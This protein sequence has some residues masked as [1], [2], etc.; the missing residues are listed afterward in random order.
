MGLWAIVASP[1]RWELPSLTEK[2][3]GAPF[4]SLCA[5]GFPLW[6]RLI[7]PPGRGGRPSGRAQAPQPRRLLGY[8]LAGGP[9]TCSVPQCPRS[10]GDGARLVGSCAD[11]LRALT[12]RAEPAP[13]SAPPERHRCGVRITV[14]VPP[15]P[16]G[17]Q[18]AE[19]GWQTERRQR[20]GT[21]PLFSR[22]EGGSPEMP[23]ESWWGGGSFPPPPAQA[24]P[25]LPWLWR[26]VWRRGGVPSSRVDCDPVPAAT[27]CSTDTGHLFPSPAPQFPHLY[28]EGLSW[29]HPELP[30][31]L[32]VLSGCGGGRGRQPAPGEA[33]AGQAL[34]LEPAQGAGSPRLPRSFTL[35]AVSSFS[36]PPPPPALQL[37]QLRKSSEVMESW[38]C[39]PSQGLGRM[40]AKT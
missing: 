8:P 4:P 27:E 30:A 40:A 14:V 7:R 22:A 3:A 29:A 25:F 1:H 10:H 26:A 5:G 35:P 24:T 16:L 34:R 19:G 39:A 9:W 2:T 32:Q 13:W 6:P 36:S 12:F 33:S 23:P 20:A 31:A 15:R 37:A 21:T 28:K 11:R 38:G 18:E 17:S